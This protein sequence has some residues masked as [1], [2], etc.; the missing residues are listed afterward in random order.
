MSIFN[1]LF[2]IV[3]ILMSLSKTWQATKFFICEILIM[4]AMIVIIIIM[5]VITFII[6]VIVKYLN[7]I[8]ILFL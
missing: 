4:K 1:Y 5:I 8:I 7:V 6:I 2:S 3:I